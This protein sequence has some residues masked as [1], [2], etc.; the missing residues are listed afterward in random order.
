MTNIAMER[1]NIFK[2]GNIY[3]WAISHVDIA[4]LET[5]P[6]VICY[7]PMENHHRNS[8]FSQEKW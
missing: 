7:I 1:S 6:L 5:Y 8:E 4:H 3:K 2:N